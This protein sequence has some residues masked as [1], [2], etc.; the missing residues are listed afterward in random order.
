MAWHASEVET[1]GGGEGREER[2]EE[3]R[4]GGVSFDGKATGRRR[5]GEGL[6]W[7]GNGNE[8]N[9]IRCHAI[10]EMNIVK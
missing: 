6:A 10:D 2:E 9:G 5:F 1:D 3:G 8:V 7:Y 4:G